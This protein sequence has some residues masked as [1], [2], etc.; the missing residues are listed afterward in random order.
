MVR[1]QLGGVSRRRRRQCDERQVW[2][3]GS[4]IRILK[5][6]GLVMAGASHSRRD[7]R[8]Q[9]CRHDDRVASV[10]NCGEDGQALGVAGF[11]GIE[12]VHEDARVNCVAEVPG[13][14]RSHRPPR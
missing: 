3:R 7:F 13:T 11:V 10:L 2:Q 6:T 4:R 14:S 9:Q 8:E 5:R 1:G 12:R